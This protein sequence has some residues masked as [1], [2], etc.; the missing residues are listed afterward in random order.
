[1][2]RPIFKDLQDVRESMYNYL[3]RGGGT[4]LGGQNI[5]VKEFDAFIDG[6]GAPGDAKT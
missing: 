4:N 3:A 5:S 2:I 1:M 6:E